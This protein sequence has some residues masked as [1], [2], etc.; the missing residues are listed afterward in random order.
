MASLGVPDVAACIDLGGRVTRE[1]AIGVVR[2]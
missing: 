1:T 2:T